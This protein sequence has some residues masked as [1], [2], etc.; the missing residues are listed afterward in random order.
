MKIES[1]P[2]FNCVNRGS[3]LHLW[4]DINTVVTNDDWRVNFKIL[5]KDIKIKIID[6]FVGLLPYENLITKK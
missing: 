4:I 3:F 1:R 2:N 6:E 5:P